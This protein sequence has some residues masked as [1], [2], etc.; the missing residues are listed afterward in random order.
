VCLKTEVRLKTEVCLKTEVR[1]KT[2]VCL[3]TKSA[4]ENSVRP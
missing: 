3:K 1:L 4:S 2:E